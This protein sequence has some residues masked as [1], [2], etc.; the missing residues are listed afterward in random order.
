MA[1]CRKPIP[2][3]RSNFVCLSVLLLSFKIGKT[4]CKSSLICEG[5]SLNVI[6]V[7]CL[8]L[9]WVVLCFL[10]AALYTY[11]VSVNLIYDWEIVSL[12]NF[13][14]VV[15]HQM[16]VISILQISFSWATSSSWP[17][18][19]WMRMIWIPFSLVLTHLVAL[20][21]NCVGIMRVGVKPW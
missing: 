8:L 15:F 17:W 19:F 20:M 6:R 16:H 1:I 5:I 11:K 10:L 13:T 18:L 21:D 2:W 12:G 9:G 3:L 4:A 7:F 14:K